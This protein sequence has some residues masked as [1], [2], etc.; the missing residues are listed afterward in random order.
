[1]W[2]WSVDVFPL[3]DLDCPDTWSTLRELLDEHSE[4]HME[5]QHIMRHMLT[6]ATPS[7]LP[8]ISV[9]SGF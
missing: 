1:M 4:K 7:S 8:L 2:V 5:R 3:D 6:M 9:L